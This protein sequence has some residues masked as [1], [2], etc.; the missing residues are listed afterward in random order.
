LKYLRN[1]GLVVFEGATKTGKYRVTR[2]YL[3]ADE[4]GYSPLALRIAKF[5]V[6][7][8]KKGDGSEPTIKL[9][10]LAKAVSASAE[11]LPH[12]L[13]ELKA[14]G[15]VKLQGQS[16]QPTAAL[17]AELDHLWMPWQPSEDAAIISNDVVKIENFQ[18]NHEQ[19]T[20]RYGWKIRRVNPAIYRFKAQTSHSSDK[21][22][23]PH[24]FALPEDACLSWERGKS[25]AHDFLRYALSSTSKE[26]GHEEVL[27]LRCMRSLFTC[28]SHELFIAIKR[29]AS[30]TEGVYL[31]STPE[32]M[33]R[34]D[35]LQYLQELEKDLEKKNIRI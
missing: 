2:E 34:V 16:T 24:Q 29:E 19:I 8:A 22:T 30:A 32:K 33:R 26:S 14:T 25:A 21:Q 6:S 3:Q 1:I 5:S 12:A 13:S 23:R 27:I 20:A 35:F 17:F 31:A 9:H 18:P 10:K 28:M 11:K 15:L 7:N 4:T